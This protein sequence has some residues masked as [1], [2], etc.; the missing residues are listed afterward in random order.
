M[1]E[2]HAK[3]A[4]QAFEQATGTTIFRPRGHQLETEPGP[5]ESKGPVNA[6]PQS[7][8]GKLF[9][10][11][12]KIIANGLEPE[13]PS[14]A[15]ISPE[16]C[17]LYKGRIN[18]IHSEPGVGKTNLALCFAQTVT[19]EGGHVVFIDPEDTPVG[20]LTRLKAFGADMQ[21]VVEQ[22]HYLHNPTLEEFGAAISWTARNRPDLVI[23]DGLAEALAAEGKNEDKVGDVLS[24]FRY[25]LRPFAELGG[26]AVLVSDHVSKSTEDR[27][28]WAR[29]SGAKL[30]RY[31]GVSYSAELLESYSSTQAGKVS[32]KIAK[33]RNG[34]V[35]TVG[36]IVGDIAFSPNGSTTHFEFRE[37]EHTNKFR[38]TTIMAKVCAHLEKF[39]DASKNDLRK[40]GKSQYV[41]QAISCLVEEGFLSI[42][43]EGQ[44][45]Q[46]AVLKHYTSLDK[47]Q[48]DLV[49]EVRTAVE[50][51]M[52]K[53][54]S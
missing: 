39:R 30:G 7:D 33:D 3:K 1:N 36:Q 48:Q 53:K 17:M 44:R 2:T 27:G 22:F 18:E 20:I 24:F 6:N 13:R 11:L 35:G 52:F 10:D 41:D 40:L 16:R 42:S 28:R 14:V 12:G 38:P 47:D 23:L 32:L 8:P 46:F 21:M 54:A 49:Q 9:V 19:K 43:K 50:A 5:L 4:S 29:G 51:G 25:R 15:R 34:G 26:A 45:T 31:D 37:H